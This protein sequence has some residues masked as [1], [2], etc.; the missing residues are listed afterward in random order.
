M[1]E[2][3]KNAQGEKRTIS[4]LVIAPI[5]AG[6]IVILLIILFPS[7][8]ITPE[9]PIILAEA[10][11]Y[12]EAIDNEA[13]RDHALRDIAVALAKVGDTEEAIRMAKSISEEYEIALA[14][15]GVADARADAGDIPNSERVL[16]LV[17]QH[18]SAI[19]PFDSH[20]KSNA[21]AHMAKS[22]AKMGQFQTARKLVS[23]SEDNIDLPMVLGEI[24]KRQAF[25]GNVSAAIKTLSDIGYYDS[26]T[27]CIELVKKGKDNDSLEIAKAV[28]DVGD[29]DSTMIAISVAQAET[30]D[31]QGAAET[32]GSIQDVDSKASAWIRII[33]MHR[34][35]N[36]TVFPPELLEKALIDVQNSSWTHIRT[37]GLRNIAIA[38]FEESNIDKAKHLLQ[39]ALQ[40]AGKENGI[41]LWSVAEGYA[42]IGETNEAMKIAEQTKGEEREGVLVSIAIGMWR[43]GMLEESIKTIEKVNDPLEKASGLKAIVEM[44]LERKNQDANA[45]QSLQKVSLLLGSIKGML[46]D[47]P[48]RDRDPKYIALR[49]LVIGQVKFA[50]WQGAVRTANIMR[51][52]YGNAPWPL[53]GWVLND[54]AHAQAKMG[55]EHKALSLVKKYRDPITKTYILLGI[56]VGMLEKRESVGNSNSGN[57]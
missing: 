54:I 40:I 51:R 3:D 27:I 50:D 16:G 6:V 4:I 2:T 32:I 23:I 46:D 21:Q 28:D 14:L 36:A 20:L 12:A 44:I 35:N 17:P 11:K 15:V 31:I 41:N 38:T 26:W 9:I 45:I 57:N 34:K 29:R 22:Y 39:E 43:A 8:K 19:D 56:A 13:K 5:I 25:A 33:D 1:T 30:G 7:A 48:V 47:R 49:T 52:D 53:T 10:R 18:I 37:M 55:L 42:S 24:A